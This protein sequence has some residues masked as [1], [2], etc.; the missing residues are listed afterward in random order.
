MWLVVVMSG[1]VMSMEFRGSA[2]GLLFV[3]DT[4]LGEGAL[5]S[6]LGSAV[7]FHRYQSGQH[8]LIKCSAV[9]A[10]DLLGLFS[11][12]RLIKKKSN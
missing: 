9:L 7:V 6:P 8:L 3:E 1:S 12:M 2:L 10:P 11:L 5:A 4:R